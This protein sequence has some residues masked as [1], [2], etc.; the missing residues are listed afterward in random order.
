MADR[1]SLH[2]DKLEAFAAW[3]CANGWTREP[4]KGPHEVL[5][6]CRSNKPPVVVYKR[7]HN[8]RGNDVAH[9]TLPSGIAVLM[10]RAWQDSQSGFKRASARVAKFLKEQDNG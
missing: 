3:C 10:F 8:A 1:C 9:V 4:T 7:E 2:V 6:L 5:R